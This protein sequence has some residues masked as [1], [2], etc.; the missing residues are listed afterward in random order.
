MESVNVAFVVLVILLRHKSPFMPVRLHVNVKLVVTLLQTVLLASSVT[1]KVA[2]AVH[3]SLVV[4]LTGH[5]GLAAS[6]VD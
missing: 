5:I 4:V 3:L 2:Q 6:I 1:L